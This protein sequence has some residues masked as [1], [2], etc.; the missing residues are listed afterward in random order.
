MFPPKGN[1]P[2]TILNVSCENG[3]QAVR[4]SQKVL[5]RSASDLSSA[6]PQP[7][8]WARPGCLAVPL[9]LQH[10]LPPPA[11]T[12][13]SPGAVRGAALITDGGTSSSANMGVLRVLKPGPAHGT[14]LS[15]P[16]GW[17][18]ADLSA[19][20]FSE[21]DRSRVHLLDALL[22]ACSCQE[23][24][25]GCVGGKAGRAL[26]PRMGRGSKTSFPS[27][28]LGFDSQEVMSNHTDRLG[29]IPNLHLC[30]LLVQVQT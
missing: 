3:N 12:L 22:L 30:W 4:E 19:F 5:Q 6:F 20:L 21:R 10:C 2:F 15:E 13:G 27:K 24:A 18:P 11:R 28:V 1:Q 8:S 29:Q 14:A 7:E 25:Q 26:P 16:V 23:V 9:G 17:L